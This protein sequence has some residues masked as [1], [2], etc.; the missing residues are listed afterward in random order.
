ML[1]WAVLPGCG[2]QGG[3]QDSKARGYR[4]IRLAAN[5]LQ[6]LADLE[7]HP[8]NEPCDRVNTKAKREILSALQKPP[9]NPSAGTG[10]QSEH[11]IAFQGSFLVDLPKKVPPSTEWS[12]FIFGWE[13]L[14]QFYLKNKSNPD[15]RVWTQL[16]VRGRSLL[17]EDKRRIV[18][19]RNYGIH[20]NNLDSL[21]KIMASAASCQKDPACSRP[22]LDLDTELALR[23]I[24]FYK[25]FL[26]QLDAEEAPEAKKALFPVFLDRLKEDL[27]TFSFR[28]N[29]GVRLSTKEA[30][31][32]LLSLELDAG[33][34]NGEEQTLIESMVEGVWKSP[35]ARVELVWKRSSDALNLFRFLFDPKNPGERPYVVRKEKTVNLFPGN[36]TRSIAHEFG[37]VLGF[38]DHY[39]TTWDAAQCRYIEE[40]N[41]LDLMSDSSSG[42]VTEAEWQDLS[43]PQ[44]PA[45]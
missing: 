18:G 44:S 8:A 15:P 6:E 43:R 41:P 31:S 26:E 40:S 2:N 42:D 1:I 24:P 34:L 35:G 36:R 19:R 12:S 29:P 33:A 13:E 37:H 22:A 25:A 27:E 16:N 32:T 9:I 21:P 3:P 17:L 28:A 23:S 14:H 4:D 39:Y 38:P 30:G 20:R 11:L 5:L 10:G 45:R 7:T